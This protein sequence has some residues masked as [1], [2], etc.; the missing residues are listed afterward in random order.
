M[1]AAAIGTR[2]NCQP[3]EEA[4]AMWE[5]RVAGVRSQRSEVRSQETGIRSSRIHEWLGDW[6]R[7]RSH[8]QKVA[9]KPPPRG[10][11]YLLYL[12]IPNLEPGS[13]NIG[14]LRESLVRS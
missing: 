6:T 11:P 10:P 14:T 7:L 8:R 4:S 3:G 13:A 12:R 5:F 1:S 2:T 9:W